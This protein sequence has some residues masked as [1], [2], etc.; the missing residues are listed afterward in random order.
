MN[1][2][3][4]KVMRCLRYG[5]GDRMHVILNGEKLEEVDLLIH[6]VASGSG[7]RL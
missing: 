6:G 2:C 7:W 1:V 5:N 3:K 4:S